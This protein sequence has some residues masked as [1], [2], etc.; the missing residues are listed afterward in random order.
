MIVVY[1]TYNFLPH[2]CVSFLPGNFILNQD[3]EAGPV[4][5]YRTFNEKLHRALNDI[6]SDVLHYNENEFWLYRPD[7]EFIEYYA[8]RYRMIN[9]A[10]ALPLARGLH[11]NVYRKASVSRD[12]VSYLLPYIIHPLEV[13]RLLIELNIALPADECDILFAAALCHDL[14]EDVEFEHGGTELKE[15]YHL[16]PRVYETIL[17]VTKRKDFTEDEERR[18]FENITKNRLA[19]LVKAADRGNNVE[20]LYNRS[21]WKVHEYVGETK[22][23]FFPMLEYAAANYKDISSSISILRDKIY[24]LT[25]AAEFL[26]DRYDQQE[27]KLRR[28]IAKLRAEN[29][30]LRKT[31]NERWHQSVEEMC[32]DLRAQTDQ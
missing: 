12:D 16:D 19:M 24:T 21:S 17:L 25:V 30:S 3:L 23:Y 13:C 26:V 32:S 15:L 11:D 6:G 31:W 7:Y 9:T 22:K 1:F 27:S 28:R 4:E 29:D 10:I 2:S 8:A 5:D 20:D 14:I 18:H